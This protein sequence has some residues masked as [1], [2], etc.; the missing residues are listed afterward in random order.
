MLTCGRACGA[1]WSAPHGVKWPYCWLSY[2]REIDMDARRLHVIFSQRSNQSTWHVDYD[3]T[4]Y[5][6]QL[7]HDRSLSFSLVCDK[8]QYLGTRCFDDAE[9][10]LE[11]G[12]WSQPV[13]SLFIS[14]TQSKCDVCRAP[15]RLRAMLRVLAR[16]PCARTSLYLSLA[17][18]VSALQ[19]TW[20][21]PHC[22]P[23]T[24]T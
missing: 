7:D 1:A 19:C 12:S 3:N 15:H 18:A 10:Q 8:L 14:H 4:L 24:I 22:G 17:E 5:I 2:M 20:V 16:C 9:V 13:F 11:W 6:Y 23:S 21:W